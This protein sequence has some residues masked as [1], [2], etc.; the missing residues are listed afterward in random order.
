VGRSGESVVKPLRQ[1]E[2]RL[3]INST[4]DIDNHFLVS[5]FWVFKSMMQ[6]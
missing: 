2:D 5:S 6:Y 4:R 3:F 1:T